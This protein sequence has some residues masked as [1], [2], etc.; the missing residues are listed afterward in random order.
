MQPNRHA[1]FRVPGLRD[2]GAVHAGHDELAGVVHG[3][4][5]DLESAVREVRVALVL[6]YALGLGRWVHRVNPLLR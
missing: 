3:D 1:D 4:I 2:E 6:V 5:G